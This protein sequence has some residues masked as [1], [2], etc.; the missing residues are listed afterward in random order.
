MRSSTMWAESRRS[1]WR[2][3]RKEGNSSNEI[4]VVWVKVVC[5]CGC[6][7]EYWWRE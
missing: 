6:V 4:E 3:K 2:K 5:G 1:V 7:K